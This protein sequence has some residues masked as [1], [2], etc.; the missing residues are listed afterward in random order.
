[1]TRSKTFVALAALVGGLVMGPAAASA[2]EATNPLNVRSGPGVNYG[3]VDVI[4][5]GQYVE[6]T[7]TSGG[8]CYLQKSGPDGW[9]SCRYLTDTPARPGRPGRPDRDRGQPDVGIEFSIPGFSFSFGDGDFRRPDRRPDRGGRVCFYEH[10]NYEG[11]QFCMRP[12]QSRSSLGDWNDTISSIRVRG[13]AEAR[14][15]EHNGFEGRCAT[16]DRNVRNLGSRGNDQISSIRV[17]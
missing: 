17:R 16:I 11:D 6:V 12:G 9:A 10:V 14:V 8:W 7:R 2:A 13:G 3:V 4:H 1:M 15:C 5:P